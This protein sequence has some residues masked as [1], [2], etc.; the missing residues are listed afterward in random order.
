MRSF[1]LNYEVSMMLTGGDIVRPLP[2]GRGRPTARCPRELTIEEWR[3]RS[4]VERYL[5]NAMRL[6]SALQ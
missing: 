2:R 3:E 5:D 1:A 4:W 6:T